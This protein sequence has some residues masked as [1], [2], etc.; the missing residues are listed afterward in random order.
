MRA[1]AGPVRRTT[2][3]WRTFRH[4]E[5]GAAMDLKLFARVI[6]RFRYL[7]GGAL[8]L[9]LVLAYA[10]YAQ[11]GGQERWTSESSLL[12]TQR[13]FPWGRVAI[14][15]EATPVIEPGGEPEPFTPEYADPSRLTSL[16]TLYAQLAES[17]QVRALV[18]ADGGLEPGA[19]IDAR[20][21]VGGANDDESLPLIAVTTVAGTAEGSLQL[22]QRVSDAFKQYL[23]AEQERNEIPPDQRV[24]VDVVKQPGSE[25]PGVATLVQGRSLTR[26][27]VLFIALAIAAIGL[28]FILENLRP[29]R[30]P[31]PDDRDAVPPAA[32]GAKPAGR[33][34]GRDRLARTPSSGT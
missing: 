13:G 30:R 6:W 2:R 1:L 11:S 26:P 4:T 29:A 3:M 16:A 22:T 28:A 21:I 31:S 15:V 10:T 12:V 5:W 18:I 24:R 20:P 14:P 17:D 9:G 32:D 33:G 19:L 34:R 7:V 23:L 27:A 8:V 25:V